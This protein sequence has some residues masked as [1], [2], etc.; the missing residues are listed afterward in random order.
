[1]NMGLNG[2][3]RLQKKWNLKIGYKVAVVTVKREVKVNESL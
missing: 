1:M 3:D 2:I